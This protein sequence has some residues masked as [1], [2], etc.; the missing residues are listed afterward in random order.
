M[1][2]YNIFS[3]SSLMQNSLPL[4][5]IKTAVIWSPLFNT[6][7]INGLEWLIQMATEVTV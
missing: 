3:A 1:L 2:Y 6:S 5:R 4:V 7:N